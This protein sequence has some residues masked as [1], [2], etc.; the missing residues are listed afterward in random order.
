MKLQW[1]S[2]VVRESD[3]VAT[4]VHPRRTAGAYNA[5]ATGLHDR[6]SEVDD[7]SKHLI[8]VVVQLVALIPE[9]G[10]RQY[11]LATGRDSGRAGW[12]TSR[13][14][15]IGSRATHDTTIRFF[16]LANALRGEITT[17]RL[18]DIVITAVGVTTSS[19]IRWRRRPPAELP[20]RK[21]QSS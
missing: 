17:R 4:A 5:A 8:P 20:S 1:P 12:V 9:C 15:E 3:G 19:I 2:R 10:A 21:S 13:R 14:S 6:R 11:H 7:V 18:R 16:N